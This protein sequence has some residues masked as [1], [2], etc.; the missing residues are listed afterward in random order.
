MIWIHTGS[1]ESTH[2]AKNALGFTSCNSVHLRS[3]NFIRTS[4]FSICT[5]W[6]KSCLIWPC[7][8]YFVLSC[9]VSPSSISIKL[10]LNKTCTFWTDIE[11][12]PI[13]PLLKFKIFP[14]LHCASIL[15][16]LWKCPN[17]EL[18]IDITMGMV[19][20]P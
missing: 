9:F 17:Q 12:K 16:I 4:I 19:T 15:I 1:L 14:S 18:L 20:H 8:L 7:D 5:R 10:V 13:K 11:K 3:A 2:E 6:A